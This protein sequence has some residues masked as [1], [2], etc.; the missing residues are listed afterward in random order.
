MLDYKM[1]AAIKVRIYSLE[2]IDKDCCSS[3]MTVQ[4]KYINRCLK[5]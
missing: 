1:L 2:G 5:W 3:M 4:S